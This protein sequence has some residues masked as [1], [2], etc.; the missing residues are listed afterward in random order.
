MNDRI[1]I[2]FDSECMLCNATVQWILKH[3]KKHDVQFAPLHGVTFNELSI[4][5]EVLPDSILVWKDNDLYMKTSAI[6]HVLQGM[7]GKWKILSGLMR[8]IPLFLSNFIYDFI[9]GKR[10]EWFGRTA[11]CMLMQGPMKHR[12]L[13]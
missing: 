8:I 6:I 5:R 4:E 11:E 10:Y 12:F 2:F 3:E 13:D 7:G 1:I 9:A